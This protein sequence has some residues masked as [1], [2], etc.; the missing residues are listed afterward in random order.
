MTDHLEQFIASIDQCVD[1]KYHGTSYTESYVAFLDIL[2]MKE[3]T[4]R[5]YQELRN[6][7]NAL[8]SGRKLYSKVHTPQGSFISPEMLNVTIMSDAVVMSIDARQS[9]AFAMLVGFTSNMISKLLH[10]TEP[11]VF[12]RGGIT[13]G[14]IFHRGD[15][16]FGP[17]LVKAY[18]LENA[19]AKSMRCIVAWDLIN[20]D[21]DVKR[22]IENN[23]SL[24][25]DPEDRYYFID[26]ATEQLR[27]KLVKSAQRMTESDC[28]QTVKDKYLWLERYLNDW[29]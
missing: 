11:T 10:K 16:V 17:G 12:L 4:N 1:K 20:N 18:T 21:H 28:P 9:N 2:G 13:K 6:V 23:S 24:K 29:K 15:Q 3:L 26:F 8:E 22:Y 5:P 14:D 25:K 19:H 7:F 27:P